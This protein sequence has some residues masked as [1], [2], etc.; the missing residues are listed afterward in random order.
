MVCR[1]DVRYSLRRY[2]IS[3]EEKLSKRMEA[4]LLIS[5]TPPEDGNDLAKKQVRFQPTVTIEEAASIHSE[6]KEWLQP[7]DETMCFFRHFSSTNSWLFKTYLEDE[8]KRMKEP[9]RDSSGT[10]IQQQKLKSLHRVSLRTQ[11]S[12]MLLNV[13][14]FDDDEDDCEDD[15]KHDDALQPLKLG[16]ISPEVRM[17]TLVIYLL[18]LYMLFRRS[19]TQRCKEPKTNLKG[20][21]AETLS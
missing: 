14:G 10:P 19:L 4:T 18:V 5:T 12:P 17:D 8:M 20:F 1:E 6:V 15:M 9:K 3:A 13:Y 2:G 11:N 7:L 16:P 21:L